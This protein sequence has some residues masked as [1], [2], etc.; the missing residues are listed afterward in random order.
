MG[1]EAEL[2]AVLAKA[3]ASVSVTVTGSVSLTT[4]HTY[5]HNIKS[6]K[7]GHLQ[8]G[9]WGYKVSWEKYRMKGNGCNGG[10]LIAKGTAKL[11]TKEVG[12]K[13]TETSS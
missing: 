13:Y 10:T 5:Q 8:Y 12:W 2:K 6:G 3:K 4:G 1:G 11:P 9:S 7:Y